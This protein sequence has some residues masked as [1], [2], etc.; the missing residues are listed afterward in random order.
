MSPFHSTKTR[1]A[2]LLHRIES[3]PIQLPNVDSSLKEAQRYH[4]LHPRPG[5]FLLI[6]I[7]SVRTI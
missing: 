1:T 5:V 3:R 6:A 4:D 7:E 2:D